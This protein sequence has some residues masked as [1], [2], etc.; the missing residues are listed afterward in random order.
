MLLGGRVGRGPGKRSAPCACRSLRL[1]QV[2]LT[3]D[4]LRAGC[5]PGVLA[6]AAGREALGRG[7]STRLPGRRGRVWT[8]DIPCLRPRKGPGVR[9]HTWAAVPSEVPGRC[10]PRLSVWGPARLPASPAPGSRRGWVS[11]LA[12]SAP[13]V[14]GGA[15]TPRKGDEGPGSPAPPRKPEP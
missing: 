12:A 6:G 4:P 2:W 5:E 14:V 9:G 8:E 7:H 3:A 1:F 15:G 11:L 10:G 13:A